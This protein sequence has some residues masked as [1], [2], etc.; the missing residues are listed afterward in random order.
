MQTKLPTFVPRRGLSGGH[1]QTL[2]SFFPPAALA[3]PPAEARFIEV[4]PGVKV[5]VHCHWQ[6]DRQ[7]ALTVII[8]HGLEGSSDSTYM[9]GIAAKGLAARHECRPHE[10]AQLRRHGGSG[11]DAL[12]FRPL[13][14]CRRG[15]AKSDRAGP[16]LPLGPGGIFHGRQSGAETGGR[17]GKRR[18]RSNFARWRRSVRRS[19]SRPRRTLCICRSNRLYEQYFLW[20]LSRR[21]RDQGSTVSGRVRHFAPARHPQPARVRRPDHGVLLRLYRRRRLLRPL[22][23]RACH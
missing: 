22:R 16:H 1:R 6:S 21:L 7:N 11:S 15:G 17:M 8:V 14:G 9:L 20:N 5:L 23:G 10:S 4:E 13:S 12:P 18:A 3:L 19:T 2:A